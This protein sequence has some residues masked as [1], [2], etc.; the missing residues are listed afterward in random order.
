MKKI[1]M[2]AAAL[3]LMGVSVRAQDAVPPPGGYTTSY[4]CIIANELC[5]IVRVGS[6]GQSATQRVDRLNERLAYIIGYERLAPGNIYIRNVKGM[7][8][9]MV[10]RSELFTVT[11]ED[12]RAVGATP[13][14]V[15]RIWLA[16]LR[17]AMPQSR[18]PA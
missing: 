2:A 18:P 6:G 9:I 10:G 5:F 7:P 16:N 8:T 11:P 17:H 14:T 13:Q 12:A 1:L 4:K 15:A 3:A